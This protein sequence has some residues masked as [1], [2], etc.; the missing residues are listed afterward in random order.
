MAVTVPSA[1]YI[2]VNK[3][4]MIPVFMEPKGRSGVI[5]KVVNCRLGRLEQRS[6][7]VK[8]GIRTF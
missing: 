8:G 1:G 6:L 7:D 3:T 4:D 5:D 2:L